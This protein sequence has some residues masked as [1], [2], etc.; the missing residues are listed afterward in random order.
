MVACKDEGSLAGDESHGTYKI[1]ALVDGEWVVVAESVDAYAASYFMDESN[2][3]PDTDITTNTIK[4]TITSWYAA[5]QVDSVVAPYGE[6]LATQK[7][8][9]YHKLTI[10]GYEGDNE[11][12]AL[13][14][15]TCQQRSVLLG[16]S[17]SG[18]NAAEKIEKIPEVGDVYNYDKVKIKVV[19]VEKHRADVAEVY[20]S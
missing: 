1:E 3:Y 5:N 6:R 11:F 10:P 12:Y 17:V 8:S 2:V 14:G 4:V 20:L 16:M 13:F 15:R 18:L 9:T 7:T 19:A